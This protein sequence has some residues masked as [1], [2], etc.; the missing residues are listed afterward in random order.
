MTRAGPS[1]SPLAACCT[2]RCTTLLLSPVPLRAP[3]PPLSCSVVFGVARLLP[4]SGLPGLWLVCSVVGGGGVPG[5]GS[6]PIPRS[7]PF[8]GADACTPCQGVTLLCGPCICTRSVQMDLCC[9]QVLRPFPTPGSGTLWVPG[10]PL[11]DRR[12]SCLSRWTVCPTHNPSLDTN[13]STCSAECSWSR[14]LVTPPG[15]CHLGHLTN[16]PTL[17][18]VLRWGQYGHQRGPQ[19]HEA[20]PLASVASGLLLS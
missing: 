15:R 6:D 5:A 1:C 12:V 4:A 17:V 14:P 11:R 13:R 18:R 8:R 16:G 9:S 19:T 3:P 20:G 2:T 10:E 7:F